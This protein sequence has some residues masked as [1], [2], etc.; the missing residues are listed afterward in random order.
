MAHSL[1]DVRV[2]HLYIRTVLRRAIS[3][4]VRRWA[5]G[6]VLDV[7]CGTKRYA[8]VVGEVATMH[9]GLDHP[10]TYHAT[11]SVDVFGLADAL[12]FADASV[13]TVFCTEV[14]EHLEMPQV[15]VDESY[16]CLRPGGVAIFTCPFIWHIHEAPRDFYRYSPYGLRWLFEN[17]GFEVV[18]LEPLNRFWTT[19]GQML[20]YKLNSYN[21]G[22]LR[23]VPVIPLVVLLMQGVLLLL[24]LLPGSD[25]WPSHH[26]IVARKPAAG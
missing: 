1:R 4:A 21:R 11:R 17:A 12:P 23:L 24:D 26:L 10:S 9:V 18:Q 8:D 19:F 14:L 2:R 25:E 15:T 3:R 6:V 16:R 5:G 22:I 20:V 7:G 13:D